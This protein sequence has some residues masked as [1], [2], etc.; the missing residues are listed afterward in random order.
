MIVLD[1]L[2]DSF[3]ASMAIFIHS[4]QSD[5]NRCPHLFPSVQVGVTN[6]SC[7]LHEN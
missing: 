7:S 6:T 2:R 3:T 4:R 5:D 1:V